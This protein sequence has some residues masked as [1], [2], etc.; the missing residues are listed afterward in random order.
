M[1]SKIKY[2][3]KQNWNWQ[4]ALY[5]SLVS[6]ILASTFVWIAIVLG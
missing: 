5:I 4:I 2:W 1:I 6:V 3:I